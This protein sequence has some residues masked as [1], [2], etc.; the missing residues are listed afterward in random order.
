VPFACTITDWAMSSDGTADIQLWRVPAGG[1][2]LPTDA[3]TLSTN[4]FSLTTGSL[5]HSTTL[6]D[7]SST[8]IFAFDTFGVNLAA[9]GGSASH[10]EFYLGCSR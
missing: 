5:I 7:L 9:E 6:T 8:A 4:G 1:T 10:V 2:D 3:D